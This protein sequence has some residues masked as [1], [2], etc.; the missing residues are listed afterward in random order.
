MLHK[1]LNLRFLNIKQKSQMMNTIKLLMEYIFDLQKNS[2]DRGSVKCS[3]FVQLLVKRGQG[4]T[5]ID[6]IH[7]I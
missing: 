6:N 4:Q 1:F 7:Y 3:L 2:I 5:F